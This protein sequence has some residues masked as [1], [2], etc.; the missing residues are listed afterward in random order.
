MTD[1][2]IIDRD[3]LWQAITEQYDTCIDVAVQK[4]LSADPEEQQSA[5]IHL[6]GAAFLDE[7]RTRVM[8]NTKHTPG[9]PSGYRYDWDAG[10]VPVEEDDASV[11]ADPGT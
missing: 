10:W 8:H 11:Q 2:R 3:E 6:A 7:V 1:Y 4:S 9:I 5:L